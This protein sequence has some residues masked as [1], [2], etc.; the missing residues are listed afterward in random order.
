MGLSSDPCRPP[1]AGAADSA[2]AGH[3]LD[4][5]QAFEGQLVAVCP[6]AKSLPCGD[7]LSTASVV[8]VGPEPLH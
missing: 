6:I 8:D 7:A 2:A 4:S 1:Q 3:T 5:R